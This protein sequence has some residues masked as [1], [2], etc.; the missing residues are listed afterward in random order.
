[1]I[2][3]YFRVF[4]SYGVVTISLIMYETKKRKNKSLVGQQLAQAQKEEAR[5][6]G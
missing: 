4:A 5:N 1:M 6:N 2:G 3:E